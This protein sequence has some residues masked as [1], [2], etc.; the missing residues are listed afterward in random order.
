MG[1]D[2]RGRGFLGLLRRRRADELAQVD[3]EITAF[4]EALARYEL[5]STPPAG[6]TTAG[7][8]AAG[9]ALADYG[10]A[11]DAYERAKR[12][13]V[14][15][16]NRED[17][18]DVLRALDEGRSALARAEARRAGR[19]VPDRRP[20]CFFDPRHGP[21]TTEFR[22]A[23]PG[24]VPRPVPVCAA[25]AARLSDGLPPVTDRRPTRPTRPVRPVRAHPAPATAPATAPAAPGWRPYRTPPPGTRT[26]YRADGKGPREVR[27]HRPDPAGPALLVVRSSYEGEVHR[28]GGPGGGG[29]L[30]AHALGRTVVVLPPD[31]EAHVRLR[32]EKR[33]PWQLWLQTPE[34]VPVLERGLSFKGRYV[35]RY[36]GGPAGIR[37][38]H[39]GSGSCW[40][41]RLTD[42]FGP[43][44]RAVGGKGTCDLVGELPGPG[45][46][47]VRANHDWSLT[48]S[49]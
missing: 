27:L 44:E 49:S 5:G 22:W 34:H 7:Q 26:A 35:F 8:A 28:L 31:G 17:A 6:Q 36:E 33:G 16:R 32:V 18:A 2:G 14:G 24:G 3:A 47:R 43:G 45:L 10:R 21:A 48:L 42:G 20:P 38:S 1:G 39:R 25:D 13:F 4:G 41:E 30:M 46:F 23:P 19:P 37:F 11:L 12:D 9:D 29:L 15:D 40:I